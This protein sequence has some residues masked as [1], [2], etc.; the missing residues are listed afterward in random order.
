M[1][2][3]VSS[4]AAKVFTP[5]EELFNSELDGAWEFPDL[6][7]KEF[8]GVENT[9][10]MFTLL[11]EEVSLNSSTKPQY[12][13]QNQFSSE[14]NLEQARNVWLELTYQPWSQETELG[15]DDPVL[16]VFLNEQVV[17][18]KSI[19]EICCQV[20]AEKIYLGSL[21]GEQRLTIF[22]GEMGDLLKPSGVILQ[23]VRVFGQKLAGSKSEFD[24]TAIVRPSLLADSFQG[25]GLATIA[26]F[27][28][29]TDQPDTV[30]FGAGEPA[31]QVLGETDEALGSG[32]IWQERL[33]Q[34]V[35]QPWFVWLMWLVLAGLIWL[36]IRDKNQ[37]VTDNVRLRFKNTNSSK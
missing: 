27:E 15:F 20:Q 19:F 7:E 26:Q 22:A 3:L 21:D 1:L 9:E 14:F 5:G 18:R 34:L 33:E 30:I 13:V 10:L 6:V 4:A 11:D 28:S 16:V 37:R 36:V 23:K 31:G 12:L 24:Q 29:S 32:L 25:N 17:L 2:L 35:H 8:D